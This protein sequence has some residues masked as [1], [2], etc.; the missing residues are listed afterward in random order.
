MKLNNRLLYK[1]FS[2]ILLPLG[3]TLM[4]PMIFA[5]VQGQVTVARAFL[6]PG[7]VSLAGGAVALLFLKKR[8]GIT[9]RKMLIKD[10]YLI[11]SAGAVL[12]LLLSAVPYWLCGKHIGPVDGWFMSVSSWTTTGVVS[13]SLKGIP[14]AVIL[15]KAMTCWMGGFIMLAVA[16][17]IFNK[18]GINEQGL[19]SGPSSISQQ[20]AKVTAHFTGTV[21]I[22]LIFYVVM[23]IA[24]LILL[25]LSDM[26]FFAALLNTLS[27]VST[28]G[29]I[30]VSRSSNYFVNTTY[31]R[32]VM[33]VF[34][35]LA[36]INFFEYYYVLT[37]HRMA[38]NYEV[39]SYFKILAA[40]V[41]LI[42]L[43]LMFTGTYHS[44]FPALRDSVA[45]VV[46]N[47]STSG[48]AST[49]AVNWPTTSLFILLILMMI[50]GCSVSAASGINVTRAVVFWKLIM[51]GMYKRIH[52]RSTK[53]VIVH[54][55][56][57]SAGKA[58]SITI[59]I[60]LFLMIIILAAVVVSLD[61][62]GLLTTFYAVIASITNTGTFSGTLATGDYSIF[63]APIRFFLSILMV[64]GRV[65]I[66]PVVV[67]F[68]TSFWSEK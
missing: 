50:G 34:A 32:I 28:S 67:L 58:S 35:L 7:L 45:V 21:K 5:F 63:S 46:S 55:H 41:V 49:I 2:V 47:A 1:T 39:R 57:I 10:G 60:M 17:T 37:R 9:E 16:I 6:I 56:K 27:N 62:K 54:G 33:S 12:L 61:D 4:I 38:K 25:S 40:A 30:D 26:S 24:E 44:F 20:N 15:W 22:L 42:T 31:I 36:S 14:C 3:V 48:Y 52:P 8:Q 59:F 68:S 53:A 65:G 43:D 19:L 23:T 13:I 64:V 18:L 11:V 51:R 66:Y 29:M